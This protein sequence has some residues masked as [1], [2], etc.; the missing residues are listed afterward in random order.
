MVRVKH[1]RRLTNCAE[2][3]DM[4]QAAYNTVDL[5]ES[6]SNKQRDIKNSKPFSVPNAHTFPADQVTRRVVEVVDL[7]LMQGSMPA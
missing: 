7:E 6:A 2:E 1:F 3:N 5:Q 4:S